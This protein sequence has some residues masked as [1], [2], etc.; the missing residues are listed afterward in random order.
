MSA[1]DLLVPPVVPEGGAKAKRIREHLLQRWPAEYEAGFAAG[2]GE[3]S[4]G[5]LD[6][7]GY[8]VGFHT[9][10]LDRRNAWWAGSTIG[11]VIR[12]RVAGGR[13]A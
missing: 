4:E 9:W 6:R 11:L 10:A 2:L 8:P 3:K 7:G 5:P 1:A 12:S 13:Y